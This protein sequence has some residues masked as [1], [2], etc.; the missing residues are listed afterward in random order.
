MNK[1][2]LA[3]LTALFVA[4]TVFTGCGNK[5]SDS[6]SGNS[7]I[8]SDEDYDLVIAS[9][10]NEEVESHIGDDFAKEHDLKIKYIDYVGDEN[11]NALDVMLMAQDTEV[12]IFYADVLDVSKYVRMDYYVDLKQYD[13]LKSKIESN[14]LIDYISNYEGKCFGVPT[15]PR[16]DEKDMFMYICPEFLTYCFENVDGF[17]GTYSD[18]DGEKLYELFKH[19]Y[20]N[21][22][23]KVECPLE[24]VDFKVADC[25]S[26]VMISPFSEHKDT[27]ALYLG[28]LFDY[29]KDKEPRPYPDL[30]DIDLEDTYLT[31]RSTHYK[32][33]APLYDAINK[34]LME[35]DGSEKALRK[36][37][38]ETANR[39]LMR[40]EG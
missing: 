37:A 16:Y 26:Y 21:D 11:L 12:D 27:A 20:E 17:A 9:F 2:L 23:H 34:E 8:S 24:T 35:T 29:Y 33:C 18:A 6:L 36:L 5:T 22:G 38:K 3:I 10:H 13:D 31:W 15:F 25:S 32:V 40:L 4:A 7:D 39:V 14:A 1:K 19:M 30:E 28:F